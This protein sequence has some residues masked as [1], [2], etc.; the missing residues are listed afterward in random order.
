MLRLSMSHFFIS[1]LTTLDMKFDI[2]AVYGYYKGL[3]KTG[4]VCMY[5]D[6]LHDMGLTTRFRGVQFS[7]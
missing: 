3:N 5:Y 6:L 1:E 2:A 4:H 7:P